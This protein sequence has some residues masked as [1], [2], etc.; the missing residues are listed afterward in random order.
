MLKNARNHIKFFSYNHRL[1]T[2]PSNYS[3]I[4][5][6]VWPVLEGLKGQRQKRPEATGEAV[7]CW[8]E[9][10]Q[11]KMETESPPP[12]GWQLVDCPCSCSK[13]F[14]PLTF[15]ASGGQCV[16]LFYRRH[17]MGG[18]SSIPHSSG[19]I[20]VSKIQAWMRPGF[21]WLAIFC[22]FLNVLVCVCLSI[23]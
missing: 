7:N 3:V 14:Y 22:A 17:T 13:R 1:W 8:T 4:F 23:F 12:N 2:L 19:G 16:G 5:G 15:T 9:L 21:F 20:W 18:L 11:H 6:C 10:W